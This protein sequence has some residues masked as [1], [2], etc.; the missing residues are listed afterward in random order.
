M[1][2]GSATGGVNSLERLRASRF[3]RISLSVGL[4]LIGAAIAFI[5]QLFTL[6]LLGPSAGGLVAVVQS[7][8]RL[9]GTTGALGRDRSLS[10]TLPLSESQAASQ[11][12]IRQAQRSGSIATSFILIAVLVSWTLAGNYGWQS[13]STL[14][15]T[16]MGALTFCLLV[17]AAG[18]ARGL[19]APLAADLGFTILPL[20][21]SSVMFALIGAWY[22][23]TPLL[24]L[25]C[26]VSGQAVALLYFRIVTQRSLRNWA[27]T[28]A[29]NRAVDERSSKARRLDQLAIA[30]CTTFS[31][32]YPDA[33]LIIVGYA[34]SSASAAAFGIAVRYIR[35]A[36]FVPVSFLHVREPALAQM[37]SNGDTKRLGD[38]VRTIAASSFFVSVG[39]LLPL[40]L[41]ASKF[42][43]IF[44]HSFAAFE[45]VLRFVVLA[46]LINSLALMPSSMLLIGGHFRPLATINLCVYLSG[47]II[48]GFA[49]VAFGGEGAAIV[50]VGTN[51]LLA[52]ATS[53]YCFCR[54]SI[55]ADAISSGV[56]LI[57]HKLP[58]GRSQHSGVGHPEKPRIPHPKDDNRNV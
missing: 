4:K 37:W 35:L 2:G 26:L 22:G 46:E 8:M 25:I 23:W 3:G 30:V 48:S 56:V 32:M 54:M 41:F 15:L 9:I 11:Q 39:I 57:K 27:S 34:S 1:T 49:I 6:R 29:G 38:E 51:L 14:I 36:R 31:A 40:M 53:T 28:S 33:L 10:L 12:R 55:R 58:L 18:A 17:G 5:W 44:G 42:L 13:L 20:S 50:L 47:L 19:H 52:V 24:A 7:Q 21:L 16:I 43:W 45:N